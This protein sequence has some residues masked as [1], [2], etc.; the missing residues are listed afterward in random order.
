MKYEDVSALANTITK[1]VTGRTDLLNEDLSNLVDVGEI[2]MNPRNVDVTYKVLNDETMRH[3]FSDRVYKGQMPSILRTSDEWGAVVKKTAMKK[4][5]DAEADP[6]FNLQPGQSYDPHKFYGNDP[7]QTL[8]SDEAGFMIPQSKPGIQ[9]HSAFRGPGE[10][11]R[12]FNM[13]EI[14]V[15]NSYTLKADEVGKRTITN[16]IGNVLT[17]T[18]KRRQSVNLLAEYKAAFPD[19]TVTAATAIRDPGFLRFASLT[20]SLEMSRMTEI[21]ALHNLKG[22]DRFT[23]IEDMHFVG[24]ADFVSGMNTY[25]QSDVRHN[26]FTRLPNGLE[27]VSSWQGIGTGYGWDSISAIDITPSVP[28]TEAAAEVKQTGIIAVLFDHWALGEFFHD[29]H[30]TSEWNPLG[31]FYNSFYKM[32]GG[33]FNDTAE[34]F[35]VFYIADTE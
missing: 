20:I 24:L 6:A 27:T 29:N 9:L 23:P 30:V 14:W 16:M 11:N 5:A 4:L 13:F 3:I 32:R 8:F 28:G 17:A 35:V 18:D 2:L 33:W 10:L 15:K 34:Q 19:A 26:E 21:N 12:F 25:L 1:E 22:Y 7:E 31:E